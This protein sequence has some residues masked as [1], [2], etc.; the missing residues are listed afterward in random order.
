MH[1][2]P[3]SITAHRLASAWALIVAISLS[4]GV[5]AAAETVTLVIDF[6]GGKVKTFD[7]LA[8]RDGMTARDAMNQ[9]KDAQG[10]ITFAQRGR[11]E[12]AFLTAIDG[13]KNEGGGLEGRNW[14]YRVN[15][16]LA[17][18]GFA[19]RKLEASDT[20]QWKFGPLK[21]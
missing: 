15:G 5:A 4:A 11:G 10:G 12:T 6:G 18:V 19:V 7:K 21:K 13:V 17:K 8:H 14:T 2:N 16:K 3:R 9:A 20:V 1:F